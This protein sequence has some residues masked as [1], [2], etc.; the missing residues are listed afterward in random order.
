MGFQGIIVVLCMVFRRYDKE[1]MKNSNM[2]AT[3]SARE[4]RLIEA[5]YGP[6]TKIVRV[7]LLRGFIGGISFI[8]YFYSMSAIPL[9]DAITLFSIYPIITIVIAYFVLGESVNRTKVLA[10]TIS[11]VGATLIAGPS[12]Y[13][14][15]KTN[16]SSA[17]GY[18]AAVFASFFGASVMVLIRKAGNLGANTFNL[19]FS[20]CTSAIGYTVI[21]GMNPW[22]GKLLLGEGPWIWKANVLLDNTL[23]W[24][25]FG[26]CFFGTVAHFLMNYAGKLAPAGLGSI[27]RSSDILW[28][29]LWE[30]GMFRQVPTWTTWLGV[31]FVLFSIVLVALLQ[32]ES[33]GNR[34]GKETN[35]LL[36]TNQVFDEE[37]KEDEL[38]DS[39]PSKP[40]VKSYYGSFTKSTNSST[41]DE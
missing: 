37:K 6:S 38:V 9:G 36:P 35:P 21:I 12:F 33:K 24:N 15:K 1:S 41:L 5:P 29:Y 3:T 27:A 25:I 11:V 20:W 34:N 23:L 39:M 19:L 4:K 14:F 31:A 30:L 40:F 7:V 32:S 10:A 13:Q 18:L 8:L 17:F 22:I 2:K 16:D 28:G 26:M